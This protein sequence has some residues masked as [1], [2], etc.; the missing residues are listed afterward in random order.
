MNIANNK[1]TSE[2]VAYH[3]I[4]RKFSDLLDMQNEDPD[5]LEIYE[6]KGEDN[7]CWQTKG[8]IMSYV[9]AGHYCDI[10][11]LRK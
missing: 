1:Y 3:K 2:I 9:G 7:S 5:Q 11:S 8:R 4:K 6:F 10:Y